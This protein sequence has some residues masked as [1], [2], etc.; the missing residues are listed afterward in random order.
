M[1]RD[2]IVNS[3]GLCYTYQNDGL[4]G[5]ISRPFSPESAVRGSEVPGQ[6]P[7]SLHRVAPHVA[8]RTG[9][10]IQRL[11]CRTSPGPSG[12]KRDRLASFASTVRSTL[13]ALLL[14]PPFHAPGTQLAHSL[15]HSE[16]SRS[17]FVIV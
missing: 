2:R 11:S 1:G 15:V 8:R 17:C 9:P 4:C 16:V 3:R 12:V 14:R 5:S 10:T 6:V 13:S 7:E